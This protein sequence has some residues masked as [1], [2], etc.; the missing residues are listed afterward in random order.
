MDLPTIP[1]GFPGHVE[2]WLAVKFD[3]SLE[4][5]SKYFL[6]KC[7]AYSNDQERRVVDFNMGFADFRP[8]TMSAFQMSARLQRTIEK[9]K[10]QSD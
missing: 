4:D 3:A 2:E 1:Q 10:Q 6:E 9:Y 5:N 7:K 8:T